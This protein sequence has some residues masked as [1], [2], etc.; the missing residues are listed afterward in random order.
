MLKK[1]RKVTDLEL[2]KCDTFC[3]TEYIRRSTKNETKRNKKSKMFSSSEFSAFLKR[4]KPAAIEQCK[5]NFCNPKCSFLGKNYPIRSFC[6]VC[7]KKSM[8][9]EKQGAITYCAYDPNVE[10]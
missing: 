7:R 5:R 6:P 1:S 2:K 8:G 10:I 3:K 9:V 4:R